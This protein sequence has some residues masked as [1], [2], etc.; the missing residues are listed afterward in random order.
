MKERTERTRR[1]RFL[2]WCK[3][4]GQDPQDDGAWDIFRETE[5][6]WEDLDADNTAGWTDDITKI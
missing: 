2:E 4:T 3:Q 5:Y 6:F 1:E